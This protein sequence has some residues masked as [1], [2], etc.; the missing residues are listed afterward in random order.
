M[1]KEAAKRTEKK[2]P[3]RGRKIPQIF[4]NDDDV[5]DD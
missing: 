4:A 5:Y 3:L 1:D 2:K